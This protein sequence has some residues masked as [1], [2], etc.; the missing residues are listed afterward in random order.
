MDGTTSPRWGSGH[1]PGSS[2]WADMLGAP[3][4]ATIPRAWCRVPVAAGPAA[5]RKGATIMKRV[6]R[7]ADMRVVRQQQAMAAQVAAQ[8]EVVPELDQTEPASRRR[9]NSFVPPAEDAVLELSGEPL[10][11][12]EMASTIM[13]A[14]VDVANCFLHEEYTDLSDQRSLSKKSTYSRKV[15]P[16]KRRFVDY[17]SLKFEYA[18]G[19]NGGTIYSELHPIL[20]KAVQTGVKEIDVNMAS[21][22]EAGVHLRSI[23]RRNPRVLLAASGIPELS[24]IAD[25]TESSILTLEPNE[26]MSDAKSPTKRASTQSPSPTKSNKSFRKRLSDTIVRLLPGSASRAEPSPSPIKPASPPP[27]SRDGSPRQRTPSIT[28]PKSPSARKSS[29]PVSANSTPGIIRWTTKS[30]KESPFSR[31]RPKRKSEPTPAL[32]P[33]SSPSREEPD[34]SFSDISMVDSSIMAGSPLLYSRPRAPTPSKWSGLRPSTPGRASSPAAFTTPLDERASLDLVRSLPEWMQHSQSSS[35]VRPYDPAHIDFQPASPS[36]S[37]SVPWVNNPAD[38]P[39]SERT[40]IVRRRKSEPLFRNMLKSQNARRIS[41]SPQ[42]SFIAQESSG[43]LPTIE[44][45]AS[46]SRDIRSPSPEHSQASVYF[47]ASSAQTNPLHN[48][49]SECTDPEQAEDMDLS[50]LSRQY[51]RRMQETCTRLAAPQ[52]E[53]NVFVEDMHR[54]ESIFGAPAIVTPAGAIKQLSSLAQNACHGNAGVK[55]V[56][57]DGRLWVRFKLPP[58]YAHLFPKN[59]LDESSPSEMAPSAPDATAYRFVKK[60]PHDEEP[61]VQANDETLVVS[62]FSVSSAQPAS[63]PPVPDNDENVDPRARANDET[64]IVSDFDTSSAR[65]AESSPSKNEEGSPTTP[66]YTEASP[67]KASQSVH[68]WDSSSS[69]S[70]LERTPDLDKAAESRIASMV[71]AVHSTAA[72]TLSSSFTPVNQTSAHTGS[73]GSANRGTE[74]EANVR[75]HDSPERDYLRDFIR[76]SRP[77]SRRPSSTESGSPV[78]PAQRLPLGARSPNME[79]Q[80]KEKRKLDSSEGDEN[81]FQ[82]SAEPPTKRVRTAPRSSPRKSTVP[83]N[84]QS[85]DEDPL[86]K[87]QAAAQAKTVENVDALANAVEPQEVPAAAAAASRRSTRLRNRPSAIPKSSIPAPVKVGRGRPPTGAT[88]GSVRTEQQDLVHQTRANTRRNKGNAEYPAQFLARLSEEDEGGDG[89]LVAGQ[90]DEAEASTA[91]RGKSVVWKEPLADFQEEE[92][93]KRGRGAAAAAKAQPASSRVSKP[94]PKP[95][96][97]TQRQRSSRLAAGLGMV[98]NGTPAPKRATRAS[99]RSQK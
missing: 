4:P 22:T 77:R 74:S 78:A 50:D 92:K 83:A 85:D 86:A 97:A 3:K 9:L 45:P 39:E 31:W 26:S 30:P 35:T 29:S 16:L 88:P 95:S 94:A 53:D 64:L 68:G 75:N 10:S 7:S 42:K 70:E 60:Y 52:G 28:I 73:S 51:T 76:R 11:R 57:S 81:E 20:S 55:V 19:G 61:G 84:S 38:A 27:P 33:L 41:F 62:D 56:E 87:D 37:G 6:G 65:P 21:I 12:A 93:P 14:K 96:A 90:Q 58:S 46:P 67:A 13:R 15:V 40:S 44:E 59:Q 89:E 24:D 49:A 8:T 1:R 72:P 32:A 79:P 48:A 69:L 47:S 23:R 63:S 17:S 2:S 43:I 80:Q 99:T 5:L 98:G 91:R 34:P 82:S 54:P 66:G 25:A 36:F 18:S 71:A